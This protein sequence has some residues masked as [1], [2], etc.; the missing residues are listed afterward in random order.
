MLILPTL[1]PLIFIPQFTSNKISRKNYEAQLYEDLLFDYNRISR[2]VKNST[3]VLHI[4]DEKNQVLTTN[5]WLEMRWSDARLQW[6]PNK[7]GGIRQLHIP[8]TDIWIPDFVLYDNAAGDPDITIFTDAL[9]SYNGRVYWQPPA[10]Y[11]SFCPIKVKWFP[12][13]KQDCRMKFGAWSYTGNYV[14]LHLIQQEN[15]ENINNKINLNKKREDDD[16]EYNEMGMDL[17]FFY[18]SAEWDLM[19][20]TSARHAVLYTSCCGPET[21]VDI[22]YYLELRR[23]TLFFTCNLIVPCFLIS[24]LTTFV[25]YLPD[26]KITFSI[27]ILV[28]LTVFFL[29]LI[30]LM[31]P[32]SLEV[33]MFGQYLITTMILVALSTLF[34]VASVNIRFRNG[35][36]HQMSPWIRIVFLGVLPK[37]LLM[38]R[39][40]RQQLET[41]TNSLNNFMG[42]TRQGLEPSSSSSS[43]NFEYSNK[44]ATISSPSNL[45]NNRSKLPQTSI[46]NKNK[47]EKYD[48][49]PPYSSITTTNT[50]KNSDKNNNSKEKNFLEENIYAEPSTSR[51]IQQQFCSNKS[52]KLK[53]IEYTWNEQRVLYNLARQVHFIAN[54]F[55]QREEDANISN[56]WTFVA[57]VL[58]RFFLL[59]FSILNMATF[60]IIISA[61]TLF[62]FREP[63][64]ITVPTRP[65]GQA[66]HLFSVNEE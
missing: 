32:T 46:V 23:K 2:P 50:H 21:Y 48:K 28:T 66:Y 54:Y 34:S 57:M 41:N 65:L 14:D 59:V 56:D 33:P 62:D 49:P 16:I 47:K 19:N 45:F 22:T 43:F 52:Q 11:K 53:K 58:D 7:Y 15:S 35:S 36:T 6:D 40:E 30:D 17:S 64:N 26:H 27:S 12:Y 39:P 8:S 63:L 42:E 25:F 3:D 4:D 55:R 29:V 20:L 5:L 60:S 1:I 24:F 13:D 18:K 51:E 44:K 31:P 61:P 38:K 10:I 37:I 9:I